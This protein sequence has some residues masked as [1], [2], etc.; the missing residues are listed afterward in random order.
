MGNFAPL[1]IFLLLI[2]GWIPPA[3]SLVLTPGEQSFLEQHPHIRLAPDP[4]FAP[5]EWFNQEGEYNGMTS[6]Y[7]RLLEHRLGIKFEIVRGK[8]WK[9]ILEMV[10][11]GEVDAVSAI[12]ATDERRQHLAFTQPYLEMARAIF[13]NRQLPG[14]QSIDDLEGYRVAVVEG[15]WMDDTLSARNDVSLNRFQDLA[16]AL[17]ATSREVTD[18]TASGLETMAFIRIREGLPNLQ[19][20][21]ELP[22]RMQLSFGVHPS[23]EPLVSIL[24]R[25]L[26][27]INAAEVTRIKN[28]WLDIQEPPFWQT[29]RFIYWALALA[30][31]VLGALATVISWNRLL[32]ARV[33]ERSAQLQAAQG[34]LMQAEKMETMGRLAA[35]IAHEVKNPLAIIQMGADYLAQALPPDDEKQPVI[36]DIGDA[37]GRAE[38]VIN[39]LLDYS[40]S[41]DLALQPRQASQIIEESLK[42]VMHELRGRN[43]KY[44][45]DIEAD[46]PDVQ[47][48]TNKIKQVLINSY[49]NA[50]QAIGRDGQLTV[51]CARLN[52]KFV[53][54]CVR[55]TGPG[56]SAEN[57]AKVFDPFF[58]TKPV[59]E[60]TGLGL[61]VS[62]NIVELHH[63][64]LDIHN[65][66]EG[67]AEMTIDLRASE[68]E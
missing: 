50:A 12:I 2:T 68:V 66:A 15:S 8:S 19:L 67:G 53:R 45:L 9:H 3:L 51:I 46:L 11:S 23:M 42:L 18:I 57:L 4:N 30:G 31:L 20:V 27:D 32:N 25:A 16:T 65:L 49:M 61:S 17:N 1:T 59:G 63:G 24:D 39:G 7:V 40:R 60:G 6:E 28:T 43:I 34:Q 13:S 48:D 35:G 33:H 37:L 58:T 21:T 14:V 29:R 38:A 47:M 56:I 55:D 52:K 54:I 64:I 22:Q 44:S 26:I 41:D 5:V 62:R 10:K 36:N